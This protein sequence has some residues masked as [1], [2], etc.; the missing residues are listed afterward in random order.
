[1]GVTEKMSGLRYTYG[2]YVNWSEDE[3]W[4]LINGIPY[5]MT[6]APSTEHQRIS[7][8]LAL[9]F[10][11]Y[12]VGK[13][14]EVFYSPFDVRLPLANEKDEEINTVVQPDLAIVCDRNK[15]D[16]KGCKGA[17]D[18]IIE[19]IS[20]A[21]AKKDMQEKFLL[22]ERS[23]VREYWLAFPLDR[24]VDVYVLNKDNK[25]QR[26]GLYQYYDKIK[27]EIFE[28][29]EIDLGLVFTNDMEIR[30]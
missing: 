21:T 27:V 14:C 11:N 30:L 7:R 23:G 1:M 19:I 12:L 25:Y 15:L 13:T 8:K 17:P 29:L 2:D 6:P 9:Q 10:A 28:D 24:V 26:S 5:D 18:L 16:E 3:R 22:Y 20:P 4:E